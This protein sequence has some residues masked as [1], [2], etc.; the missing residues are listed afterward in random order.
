MHHL[1]QMV[2]YNPWLAG[3]L[4][5]MGQTLFI[6]I[7]CRQQ[8]YCCVIDVL[9]D[10]V[11]AAPNAIGGLVAYSDS[12]NSDDEEIPHGS[13]IVKHL[14]AQ[15]AEHGMMVRPNVPS[16][17]QLVH[18]AAQLQAF[19]DSLAKSVSDSVVECRAAS[20]LKLTRLAGAL[21]LAYE[22]WQ[23]GTFSTI[24]FYEAFLREVVRCGLSAEVIADDDAIESLHQTLSPMLADDAA[25]AP[26]SLPTGWI[27]AVDPTSGDSYYCYMPS[28]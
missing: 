21:Q 27:E 4:H 11:M 24:K 5:N 8:A 25:E 23:D 13:E 3:C 19:T 17:G 16:N 28:V 20:A 1:H 2:G 6:D 18:V 26:T 10:P 12:E 9:P 7:V 14:S 15:L 22:L